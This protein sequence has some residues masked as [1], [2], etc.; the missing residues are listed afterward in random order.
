MTMRS[1]MDAVRGLAINF[2]DLCE[3]ETK[4]YKEIKCCFISIQSNLCQLERLCSIV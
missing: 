4:K 3:K 2:P 1:C